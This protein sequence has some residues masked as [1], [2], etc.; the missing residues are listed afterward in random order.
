MCTIGRHG[1]PSDFRKIT[2]LVTAQATRLFST[3]SNRSRGDRP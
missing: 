3:M 2:P 1:E